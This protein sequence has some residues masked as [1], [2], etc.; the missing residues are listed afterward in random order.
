MSYNLFEIMKIA[1]INIEE[2]N[3]SILGF[4]QEK[5]PDLRATNIEI[6]DSKVSLNSVNGFINTQ[7]NQRYFF[8]FHTEEGEENTINEYYQSRELSDAGLPILEPIYESTTPGS[9]FLIYEGIKAF[10]A[11]EE[12]EKLE[13]KPNKKQEQK[14]LSAEEKLLEQESQ[15]FLKTLKISN[16]KDIAKTPI[17]QIFHTRLV[18]KNSEP[19]RL[20]IY[21]TGKDIDLPDGKIINFNDLA[22]KKWIINGINYNETLAKIINSAKDILDPLKNK[23]IPTVLGHGDDHNGNKFYINGKFVP[24]GHFVLFDPAFAGR[25][26]ALL[27]FIKATAHNTFLHP[28]WLYD[29]TKIKGLE[30]NYKIDEYS[31]IINHNWSMEKQSPIRKKILDLQIKKVWKPL[32]T[33]MQ[34]REILPTNYEEYIHKAL[35]CCPFLV[36]NLID[37]DKYSPI[38]SLLALSKC[39]ELGT[40]GNRENYINRFLNQIKIKI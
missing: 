21:Y 28:F 1:K 5:F 32:I 6:N 16:A 39:V 29:P 37:K 30:F 9:Q 7:N 36:Y 4:V 15:I 3:A 35:F 22:Q 24:Q 20:D 13:E 27:S 8:K 10:T 25:Q 38:E 17:Y 40:T 18:A 23:K 33:E 31:I 19:P 26:P 34:K 12:F 14:L 2:A 11:F